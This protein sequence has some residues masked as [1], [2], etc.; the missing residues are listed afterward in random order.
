[1]P[2]YY[3]YNYTLRVALWREVEKLLLKDQYKHLSADALH[4]ARRDLCAERRHAQYSKPLTRACDN[5][6]PDPLHLDINMCTAFLR[7]I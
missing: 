4:E 3:G 2:V 6:A 7:L 5:D 1:M